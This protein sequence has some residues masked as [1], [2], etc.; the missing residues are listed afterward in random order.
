MLAG[1]PV[2]ARGR[3]APLDLRLF[4]AACVMTPLDVRETRVPL[5]TS[6]RELRDFCFPNGWKKKRDWPVARQSG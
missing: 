3:G 2:M 6:V 5:V 4:V 1:E